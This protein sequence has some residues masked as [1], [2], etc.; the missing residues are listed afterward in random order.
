MSEAS[1]RLEINAPIET[2]WQIMLEEFDRPDRF[3]NTI[4]TSKVIERFPDGL[5]REISVP[6]ASL[7]EKITYNFSRK[8]VVS[9]IVGHPHIVGTITKRLVPDPSCA[10]KWYLESDLE[11][12]ATDVGVENMLRRNVKEFVMERLQMV[13]TESEMKHNRQPE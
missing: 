11:W 7:R 4:K 2:I 8:E 9:N 12:E 5:L 13:R 6:D 3:S 10:D 1:Y